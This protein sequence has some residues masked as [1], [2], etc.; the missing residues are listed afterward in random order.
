MQ[1]SLVRITTPD[2]VELQGMDFR[3]SGRAAQVAV[4]HLHGT[5]G[6]F[7]G[8]PFIDYF[9]DFYP[10]HGYSFLTTNNRGH[11][12]GAITER[13]EL[14]TVDVEAWLA[15][16][17][18]LGYERIVLQ[19]HSLGA[20]KTVFYLNAARPASQVQA[21]ILLSPVDIVAF[22][23]SHDLARRSDRL[24]CA[25][26]VAQG[27]PDAI[28]SRDVSPYWL[29]SAGTYLNLVDRDTKADIFPFRAGSLVGTA[30]A[31]VDLPVFAAVGSDDFAA[32][33]TASEEFEE[34]R[35]LP[36]VQAVLIQGAPHN[37][38]QHE[39]ELLGHLAAWLPNQSRSTG[40]ILVE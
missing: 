31:C 35:Q 40:A 8:N 39:A 38:A 10:R 26:A 13:F 16:A 23:C 24:A 25:R 30:L 37:F 17:R 2:G 28:L 5:W 1:G 14:S 11:D 6:N 21:A 22:Y 18:Q 15:F 29:L 12:E 36:N 7:Y 20:L 27:D 32:H 34:L 33:P 3:G 19:G 9:A 4:V